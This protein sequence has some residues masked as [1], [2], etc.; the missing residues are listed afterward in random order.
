MRKL[1]LFRPKD[2][3]DEKQNFNSRKECF[4]NLFL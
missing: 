1:I 3:N 4:F 2:K